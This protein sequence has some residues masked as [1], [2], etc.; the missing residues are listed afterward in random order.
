MH[1][2]NVRINKIKGTKTGNAKQKERGNLTV[3]KKV[4]KKIEEFPL[5]HRG[6]KSD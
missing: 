3:Q 1:V 2:L 4:R 5:W 6:N